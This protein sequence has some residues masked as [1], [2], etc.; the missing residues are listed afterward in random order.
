LFV[1]F[2]YVVWHKGAAA[3]ALLPRCAALRAHNV[4]RAHALFCFF[5][6]RAALALLFRT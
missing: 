6:A 1:V 5:G 4:L 2:C 3:A